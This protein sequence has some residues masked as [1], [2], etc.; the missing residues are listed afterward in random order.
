MVTFF[1]FAFTG[2]EW[3]RNGSEKGGRAKFGSKIFFLN[4]WVFQQFEFFCIFG[5]AKKES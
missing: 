4:N 1:F 2:A 5:A 3:G